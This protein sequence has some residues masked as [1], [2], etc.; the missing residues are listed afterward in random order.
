MTFLLGISILTAACTTEVKANPESELDRIPDGAAGLVVVAPSQPPLDAQDRTEVIAF[1]EQGERIA[2]FLGGPTGNNQILSSP[3]R[4]IVFNSKVL[5]VL[6]SEGSVDTEIAETTIEA[7]VQNTAGD[8][9][10]IWF[11]SGVVD[12]A[13]STRYARVAADGVTINV[14]PG[15]A[16]AS[17]FCGE[18][19]Y[20]VVED[21]T[22]LA[23]DAP[24]TH[25]LYK[26]AKDGNTTVVGQ[27]SSPVGHRP[28]SRTAV[29]SQD[30]SSIINLYASR[31]AGQD[32][33]DTALSRVE[34]ELAHASIS[35][36]PV[37]M[38]GLSWGMPH[39][40]ISTKD[41]R[42]YWSTPEGEVVSIAVTGDPN[43][44]I[45]WRLPPSRR[46]QNISVTGDQLTSLRFDDVPEVSTYDLTTGSKLGESIKLPWLTEIVD[47]VTES[48]KSW[49]TVWDVESLN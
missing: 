5:R 12:G 20:A 38:L 25:R 15:M 42:V 33:R 32:S 48:G 13:Y 1:D 35:E 29:C 45:E 49:Y 17:A 10:V 7:A 2:R 39:G 19:L 28:V 37:D 21:L 36:S 11:N 23:W 41:G 6:T 30:N 31:E 18:D 44:R 14:L 34:I 26:L 27:W 46:M 16:L 47:S 8:Q 4:A 40:A 43:S 22:N 9:A 24:T 3:G